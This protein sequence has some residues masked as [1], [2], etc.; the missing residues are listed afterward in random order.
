MVLPFLRPGYEMRIEHGRFRYGRNNIIED[1]A[2][3]CG[4]LYVKLFTSDGEH[5]PMPKVW[6]Y[7][8]ISNKTEHRPRVDVNVADADPDAI[9]R[10]ERFDACGVPY[11]SCSRCGEP[12]PHEVVALAPVPGYS[13]FRRDKDA[14]LKHELLCLAARMKERPLGERRKNQKSTPY[15]NSAGRVVNNC[16][17]LQCPRVIH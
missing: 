11:T 10:I 17:G 2:D 5:V 16:P 14:E 9:A 4:N 12:I 1:T 8:L 15:V 3:D 6:L 7:A 13:W